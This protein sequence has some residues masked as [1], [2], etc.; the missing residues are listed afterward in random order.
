MY[1]SE[2]HAQVHIL[3]SRA[4]RKI[5][6]NKPDEALGVFR[7]V[8]EIAPRSLT[9]LNHMAITLAQTGRTSDAIKVFKKISKVEPCVTDFHYLGVAYTHK[10]KFQAALIS[11]NKAAKCSP[12]EPRRYLA[13]A[14]ANLH[15]NQPDAAV[16]ALYRAYALS[17]QKRYLLM[18]YEVCS[19]YD[20]REDVREIRDKIIQDSNIFMKVV[21]LLR[22]RGRSSRDDVGY[23]MTPSMHKY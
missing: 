13:I 9:A 18:I 4:R 7:E 22:M 20:T 10:G 12:K 14:K 3:L 16:Y 5:I 11:F 6:F 2:A 15:L 8:L 17:P 1:K 23:D 21:Y 19:A